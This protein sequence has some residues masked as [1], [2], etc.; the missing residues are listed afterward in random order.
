VLKDGHTPDEDPMMQEFQQ[1]I[2]LVEEL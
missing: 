1:V 2:R